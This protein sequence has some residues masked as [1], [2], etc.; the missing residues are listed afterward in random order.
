MAIHKLLLEED[1]EENFSLIAIH[2]SDEPY[3]MAYL[4]NKYI[5]LRL[6]RNRIDLNYSNNGLEITFPLFKFKN[7]LNYTY[8]YLVGN[9]CASVAANINSHGLFANNAVGRII[10]TYLLPEFKKVD[11]FLKIETEFK[12]KLLQ[13]KIDAINKI[14]EVV[15]A[16]EV[17]T[18]TIKS[19]RNLIFN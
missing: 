17:K 10:Y 18:T 11:F 14:K 1:F 15:S 3:K 2:C 4:L 19:I 6:E 16:Y 7:S 13:E 12:D 5:G 9:K 8:Y